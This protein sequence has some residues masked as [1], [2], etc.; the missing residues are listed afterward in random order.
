MENIRFVGVIVFTILLVIVLFSGFKVEILSI[1]IYV[2]FLVLLIFWEDFSSKK[3][4]RKSD[5]NNSPNKKSKKPTKMQ[6]RLRKRLIRSANINQQSQQ[7]NF[8]PSVTNQQYGEN[9]F[10]RQ[11]QP[12]ASGNLL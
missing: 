12:P 2:I 8:Q 6:R 7:S 3:Q 10:D 4:P 5:K 11:Q 1:C 9:F